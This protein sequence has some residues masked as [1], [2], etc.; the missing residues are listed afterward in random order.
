MSA[1]DSSDL[2]HIQ[3][4]PTAALLQHLHKVT[5][6]LA[7]EPLTDLL[8]RLNSLGFSWQDI[9]RASGVSVP[10]LRKWRSGSPASS[11]KRSR[12][13]SVLAFCRMAEE[14]YGIEDAAG[15][16]ETPLHPS[17]PVTGLDLMAGERFDLVL[18]L[19]STRRQDPKWILD[20]F[21]PEWRE[22]YESQVELFIAPDGLPG[23][24]LT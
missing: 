22:E 2:Y 14:N 13:A 18:E 20:R 16:L 5:V 21:Q 4:L 23:L 24:R 6:E 17:A 19:A 8:D 12:V 10:S 15:W 3:V 1:S 11:D 9:A 7:K